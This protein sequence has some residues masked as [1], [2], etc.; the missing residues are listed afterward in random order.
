MKK[1]LLCEVGLCSQGKRSDGCISR[2]RTCEVATSISKEADGEFYQQEAN[3]R[4][5]RVMYDVIFGWLSS[6]ELSDLRQT[7]PRTAP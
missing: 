5:V 4:K 6:S 3:G 1:K 2:S 7:D